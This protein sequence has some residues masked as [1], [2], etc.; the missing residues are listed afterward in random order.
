MVDAVR[1]DPS[2]FKVVLNN[3]DRWERTAS[4]GV[5]HYIKR[6]KSLALDMEAC[7]SKAIEDSEDGRAMRQS[8]PFAGV[9]SSKERFLLLKNWKLKQLNAVLASDHEKR[10]P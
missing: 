2:K 10:R 8:S 7:L 5:L 9:L 4:V 1:K 6:W 3:L